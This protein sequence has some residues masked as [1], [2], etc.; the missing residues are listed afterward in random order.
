VWL[1]KS[2]E[3]PHGVEAWLVK[4]VGHVHFALSYLVTANEWIVVW[5]SEEDGELA[6]E[7]RRNDSK[8]TAETF[9]SE[10]RK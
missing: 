9:D 7:D 1:P 5:L 10:T 3:K 6:N 2:T 8:S 4:K